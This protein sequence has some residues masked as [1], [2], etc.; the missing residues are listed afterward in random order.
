MTMQFHRKARPRPPELFAAHQPRDRATWIMVA[1]IG[2]A[3][4]TSILVLKPDL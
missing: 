4:L 3:I 1:L 2:L